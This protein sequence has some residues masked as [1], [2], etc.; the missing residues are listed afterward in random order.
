MRE[1]VDINVGVDYERARERLNLVAG[2]HFRRLYQAK[3]EQADEAT[4]ERLRQVYRKAQREMDALSPRD[5]AAIQA[6]LAKSA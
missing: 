6:V 4:I 5:E 1:E 3:R 2:A